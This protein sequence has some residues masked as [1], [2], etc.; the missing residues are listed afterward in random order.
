MKYIPYYM[1]LRYTCIIIASLII[2]QLGLELGANSEV[3]LGE[4]LR[5]LLRNTTASM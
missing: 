3:Q 5:V 4:F 1:Q 2:S